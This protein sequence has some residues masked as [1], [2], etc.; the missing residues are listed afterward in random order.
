M[1]PQFDRVTVVEIGAVIE[2]VER[3]AARPVGPHRAAALCAAADLQKIRSWVDAQEVAVARDLAACAP[4]PDYDLADAGRVSTRE[5]QTVLQ[6]A[7]VTGEVPAF[8]SALEAGAVTAGHVDAIGRAL[9]S[10]DGDARRALAERAPELSELAAGVTVKEFRAVL[11]KQVDALQH[12]GGM[13]AFDRARRANSLRLWEDHSTGV[14]RLAGQLDPQLGRNLRA[15][16]DGGVRTLFAEAV[17]AECPTDPG[18]KND[19]LRAMALASVTGADDTHN[20]SGGGIRAEVITVLRCLDDTPV[21]D[22]DM[23]LA[24]PRQV[25]TDYLTSAEIWPVVIGPSGTL[26]SAKGRLN[27][28]RTN[29]LAN[30]AQ[31][32]VLQAFHPTCA[33]DGCEVR[34]AHCDIHHLHP[35]EHGGSTDLDNLVPLCSRHHTA[36]HHHGWILTLEPD[37]TLHI[38]YPNAP[39]GHAVA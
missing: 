34:F 22:L 17:P 33:I 15:V 6:R 13:A 4:R 7:D 19:W 37:R 3:V 8:G 12:D 14:W 10:L 27:L 39:P 5:A 30:R 16:L 28:G 29:R 36:T 11:D 21:L 24:L 1:F 20:R 25:I 38:A 2:L 23:D 18:L 31:R 9:R 32:R 26:V 35:W